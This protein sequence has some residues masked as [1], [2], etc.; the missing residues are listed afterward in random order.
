MTTA[1]MANIIVSDDIRPS[2]RQRRSTINVNFVRQQ[3]QQQQQQQQPIISQTK[4]KS[5]SSKNLDSVRKPSDHEVKIFVSVENDKSDDTSIQTPTKSVASRVRNG[6]KKHSRRCQSLN[7]T[8]DYFTN[9]VDIDGNDSNNKSVITQP[10]SRN[11][12]ISQRKRERRLN[13]Q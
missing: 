10:R 9:F 12:S 2:K 3:Q 6:E 7:L 1:T 5:T 4:S 13:R 11:S 8:L